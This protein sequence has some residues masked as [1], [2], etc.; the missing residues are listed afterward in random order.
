MDGNQMK[1]TGS[2]SWVAANWRIICFGAAVVLGFSVLGQEVRAAEADALLQEI[3]ASGALEKAIERVLEK[4]ADKQRRAQ[5]FEQGQEAERRAKMAE[6][7]RPIDPARDHILGP[8]DA[9]ISIIEYSDFECPYCKRFH[10]TPQ[11]VVKTLAPAV[12]LVFRHFPLDFHDPMATREAIGALCASRQGGHQK[13]WAFANAVMVQTEGNGKGI[14]GKNDP[15]MA[16]ARLLKLDAQKF[17]D[18][19]KSK[20]VAKRVRDDIAEGANAGINGT[21]GVILRNNKTGKVIALAGAVP[22]VVLIQK[23]KELSE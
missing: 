2:G 10:E 8:L 16:L 15:L 5:E 21:P 14:P 1:S 20:E 3:E 7:V 4:L 11:Q 12:N 6:N 9:Q 22:D 17:Q 13:F 18:C 23:I 19:M